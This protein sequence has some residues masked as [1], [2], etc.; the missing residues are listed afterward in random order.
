MGLD[1][2]AGLT[3]DQLAI[4][5]LQGHVGRAGHGEVNHG[6]AIVR[7]VIQG[8]QAQRRSDGGQALGHVTRIQVHR[9]LSSTARARRI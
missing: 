1:G 2:G 7:R 4:D 6:R 9:A 8:A 3:V 5:I